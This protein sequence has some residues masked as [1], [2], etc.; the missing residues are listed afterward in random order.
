MSNKSIFEGM[1]EVPQDEMYCRSRMIRSVAATKSRLNLVEKSL[2]T[3]L[4][5]G[6]FTVTSSMQNDLIT[7]TS[8]CNRLVPSG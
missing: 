7:R 5:A 8:R 2:H 3:E 6:F 4:R 1:G